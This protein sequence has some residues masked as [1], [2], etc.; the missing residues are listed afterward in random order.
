MSSNRVAASPIPYFTPAHVVV[1]QSVV[2]CWRIV[3]GLMLI[4]FPDE[5]IG[6]TGVEERKE[7]PVTPAGKRSI[8]AAKE[9]VS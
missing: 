2:N 5:S 9:K 7:L 4:D 1:N 6:K 3:F 8:S